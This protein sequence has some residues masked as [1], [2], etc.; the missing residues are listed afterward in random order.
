VQL[1]TSHPLSIWV[2][3][4]SLDTGKKLHKGEECGCMGQDHI[5][6]VL[7]PDLC[8]L[9]HMKECV[10]RIFILSSSNVLSCIMTEIQMDQMNCSALSLLPS[11]LPGSATLV[12]YNVV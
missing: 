1:G 4:G 5:I 10:Y 11:K 6:L 3:E 7:D 12:C 8:Y 9:S 2:T